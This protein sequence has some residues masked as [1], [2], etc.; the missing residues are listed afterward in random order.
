M[1]GP[2]GQDDPASTRKVTVM[3]RWFPGF[4]PGTPE[5]VQAYRQAKFDLDRN[6][7]Y[8][9][10]LRLAGGQRAIREETPRYSDL[11]DRVCETEIPLSRTQRWWHFN[12][13]GTEQYRDMSRLQRASGR[14]D[15]ARSRGRSR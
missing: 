10:R 14:Q 15:R 8:E 6:A 11:N 13:A 12:R 3:G 7:E 2:P 5:Q 4:R 9:S 1:A